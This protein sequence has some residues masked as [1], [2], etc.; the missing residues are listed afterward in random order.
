MGCEVVVLSSTLSKKEE[1]LTLG[2]SEFHTLDFGRITHCVR[3]A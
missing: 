1:A 3:P 2:A